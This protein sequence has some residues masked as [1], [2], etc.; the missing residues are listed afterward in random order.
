MAKSKYDANTFPLLAECY[1]R[2][3]LIDVDIAK[4]LGISHETYYTYKKKYPEFFDAIK[5]G[6]KPVDY[7]VVNSL[8][9]RA[10][11]YS[12][13]EKTTELEIDSNGVPKPAKIKTVEKHIPG[14]VTAMI[15]WLKNRKP[16]KWRD[17]QEIDH[18]TKGEQ[19]NSPDL[20][21]LTVDE[22]IK[23]ADA[24]KPDKQG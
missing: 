14:D 20:S 12:F 9:K 13:Q 22:L 11:G 21:H 1:A 4:K 16:D 17:K 8:L 19:I 24:T 10:L 15:F 3:G 2:D 5:R 7:E 6:K 23:L 18:T